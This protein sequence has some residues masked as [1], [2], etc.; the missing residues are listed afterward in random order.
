MK[1]VVSDL[2]KDQPPPLKRNYKKKVL[3][4][5]EIPAPP[6][7]PQPDYIDYM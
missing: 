2:P 4:K 6:P 1:Q 3:E 5:V 7:P